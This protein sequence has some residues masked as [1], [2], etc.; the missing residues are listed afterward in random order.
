VNI[1]ANVRHGPTRAQ[2]GAAPRGGHHASSFHGQH[3]MG[4]AACRR[5]CRHRAR[6]RAGNRACGTPAIVLCRH[7]GRLRRRMAPRRGGRM[8]YGQCV[9]QQQRGRGGSEPHDRAGHDPAALA[10]GCRQHQRTGADWRRLRFRK[11]QGS[12]GRGRDG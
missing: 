6:R 10:G 11:R 7:R 5:G 4:H 12:A 8:P 1:G 9:G 3:S 2:T